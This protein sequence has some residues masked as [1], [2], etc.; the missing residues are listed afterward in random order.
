MK[1][2][3]L[4]FIFPLCPSTRRH[5]STRRF[6]NCLREIDINLCIIWQ[7]HNCRAQNDQWPMNREQESGHI[8]G[9]SFVLAQ[10]PCLRHNKWGHSRP[11]CIASSSSLALLFLLS[12]SR[13][14][15]VGNA[16]IYIYLLHWEN[17]NVLKLKI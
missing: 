17:T 13:R 4:L 16:N 10:K 15:K 2:H 7:S 9:F 11:N 12:F 6:F 3:C 1:Q 8:G 14:T 5:F